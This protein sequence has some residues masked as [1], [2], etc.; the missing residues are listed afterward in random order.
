MPLPRTADSSNFHGFPAITTEMPDHALRIFSRPSKKLAVCRDE[1]KVSLCQG[2]R[3]SKAP[4]WRGLCSESVGAFVIRAA[5]FLTLALSVAAGE[6]ATLICQA[7]C[8]PGAETD[9]E[10]C[11]HGQSAPRIS[12][13]D[14]PDCLS[15]GLAAIATPGVELNRPPSHRATALAVSNEPLMPPFECPFGPTVSSLC[16]GSPPRAIAL[17]I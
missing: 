13:A 6:S 7:V 3:F 16:V 12:A 15:I 2:G 17:R 1:Q 14:D 8:D 5:F 4:R 10:A 11:H 9:T